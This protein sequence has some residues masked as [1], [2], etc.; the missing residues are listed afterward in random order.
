[1]ET[2]W[3]GVF[4]LINVALGL[5]LYADF[6]QP[7]RR[8]L[9]LPVWDFL[10]LLGGEL[11]GEASR[12]DPIWS[13]LARLSGRRPD[14][15]P[16]MDFAA[17]TEWRLRREWLAGVGPGGPWTWTD[18][19][20]RLL[21]RHLKDFLLLDVARTGERLE[22]QLERELADLGIGDRL[23][24]TEDGGFAPSQEIGSM[25]RWLA[26][27]APFV[28]ARLASAIGF[29]DPLAATHFVLQHRA[30]A[31]ATED[32]VAVRFQLSTH[33]IELRKAGLD[34]DP[35]WVPAARRSI[36]FHYD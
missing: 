13:C 25:E 26:W 28:R 1:V 15:S 22:C 9:N 6:T 17:P 21:V 5:G 3:G 29:E 14:E 32:H 35:G 31:E 2:E 16:G 18:A 19:G 4:Y 23:P 12:M 10:E 33:P 8:G 34:R 24:L 30:K 36:G 27:L 20:G 7:R 11:A